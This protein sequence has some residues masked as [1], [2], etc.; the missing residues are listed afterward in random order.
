MMKKLLILLLALHY[1]CYAQ[2]AEQ[3][4]NY[5]NIS[6]SLIKLGEVDKAVSFLENSLKLEFRREKKIECLALLCNIHKENRNL[7]LAL[8]HGQLALPMTD[9]FITIQNI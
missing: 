7:T 1:I 5:T 8:K 9:F 4:A 6:Y 3:D 2:N